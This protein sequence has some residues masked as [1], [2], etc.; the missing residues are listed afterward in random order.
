VLDIPLLLDDAQTP[1]Y[2]RPA[3]NDGLGFEG[4]SKTVSYWRFQTSSN[5]GRGDF[6]ASE[7]LALSAQANTL[8]GCASGTSFT[9]SDSDLDSNLVAAAYN[10]ASGRGI[11]DPYTELQNWFFNFAV[12]IQ[13]QGGSA[14]AT[15]LNLATEFLTFINGASDLDRNPISFV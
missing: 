6:S 11:F 3:A 10:L 2:N 4:N 8:L 5:H 14:S 7:L 1:V 9:S 13:C 15:D 12:Y